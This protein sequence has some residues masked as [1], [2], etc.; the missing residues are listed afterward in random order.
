MTRSKAVLVELIASADSIA[1]HGHA[2]VFEAKQWE[3]ISKEFTRMHTLLGALDQ[4]A[5]VNVAC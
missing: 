3:R 5:K 1:G 2:V 4:P